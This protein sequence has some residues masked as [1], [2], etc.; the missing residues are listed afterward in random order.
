MRLGPIVL[1]VAACAAE[2]RYEIDVSQAAS[3]TLLVTVEATC[4]SAACD[5]QMPVWNATYQ[6]RDFAQ[7]VTAFETSRPHRL[8]A[9]SRW[10]VDAAAGERIRVRYRYTANAPGPFGA[11]ASSRHVFLNFAQVL[12]Y[13]V[14]R[15]REPMAVQFR[16][17]PPHWKVALELP[18]SE[19]W[20]R[21]RNYDELADAPAELAEFAEA[22]FQV[23]GRRV[24]I[25]ADGDP[26]DYDLAL[27]ESTFRRIAETATRIMQ[28]APFPS[29]TFILHFRP[30]GGGGMEHAN[31]TAID[32]RAPCRDCTLASVAAHE[33]FHLW[34]VKRIRP[35]SL[36]PIDYTRENITPSLW[37]CEGVSNAY[38]SYILLQAGLLDAET[39][40]AG[41]G[42]DITRYEQTPARLAQSAEESSVSAWLERY[43][44]Y[45]R[46]T[47]SV[48][49]YLKGELVGYLLDLA[50]RRYSSNRRSL[51]DVMRRLNTEYA[52][53][54]RFFEDTAAI[55]RL[56]SEAAGRDLHE[57]FDRLV[58]TPAPIE[59]D[60]YLGFAGYRL[61][62][63]TTQVPSLGAEA[64]RATGA[65]I[66]VS[67][68]EPDGPAGKAGLRSG[69]RLVSL[70]GRP[71]ERSLEGTLAR[72]DL[73]PGESLSVEIDR[74]GERRTLAVTPAFVQRVTYRIEEK[75]SVTAAERSVRNGWLRR[76]L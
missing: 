13:P 71:L 37:F 3:H 48:S 67:F 33:F 15:L 5:F 61:A 24:R 29:Y 11:S 42:G 46:P 30:G 17:V 68:V 28:D 25:V 34:N 60:Q 56:A 32:A 2:T 20:F 19:G 44:A 14:D 26:S 69:D 49:Y 18:R 65:G 73:K 21:A 8:V 40:L 54:G 59:W 75:P 72:L 12:L 74:R 7:Y 66:V 6:I 53:K 1:C 27:L 4:R 55:E 16:N 47:R 35:Q 58:R 76:P 38:A 57:V 36:E 22:K 52:Q 50:I 62:P 31:S 9:P 64:G 23:G 41:L 70:N 63:E 43:P 10:R 45:R 39:F 51:D